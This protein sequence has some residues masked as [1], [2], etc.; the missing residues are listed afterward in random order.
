MLVVRVVRVVGAVGVELGLDASGQGRGGATHLH[1]RPP[2][3][4]L[5]SGFCP[6]AALLHPATVHRLPPPCAMHSL[7]LPMAPLVQPGYTHDLDDVRLALRL[8]LPGKHTI[9]E[10]DG[11]CPIAMGCIW[12]PGAIMT[13]DPIDACPW[14]PC[15]CAAAWPAADCCCCCCICCIC[16]I[17]C[18]GCPGC[19]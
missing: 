10:P 3:C 18:C 19:I 12:P 14:P 13:I 6:C 8:S 17:C 11:I 7:S 16:C 4:A 1:R 5:Q 2:P 9:P 15:G